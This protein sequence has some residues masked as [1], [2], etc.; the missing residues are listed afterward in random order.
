VIFKLKRLSKK[1]F[2]QP[3]F[4][5]LKPTYFPVGF[6]VFAGYLRPPAKAWYKTA[7]LKN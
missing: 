2:K 1:L 4:H 6:G 3:L 7:A 5:F